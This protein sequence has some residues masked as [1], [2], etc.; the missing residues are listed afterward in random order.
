MGVHNVSRSFVTSD[1]AHYTTNRH[2]QENTGKTILSTSSCK[3]DSE[4]IAF[5]EVDFTNLTENQCNKFECIL[6]LVRYTS[7]DRST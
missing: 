2:I 7:R 1:T 3:D 5:Y 4:E 6:P